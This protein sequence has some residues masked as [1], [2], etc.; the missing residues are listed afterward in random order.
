M[1]KIILLFSCFFS[2]IAFAQQQTVTYSVSPAIF[3]ETTAITITIN[4]NSINESG[5]G[6]TGNALYLWAWAFAADDTTAKGTPDNGAWEA[7]SEA[8]KFTYNAATDTYTKTITPATYYNATA[9]GKIGFLI[10][11]KNGTGDKKS[12]DIFAEV[13][14]FQLTLTA[15]VENST[16]V[17]TSGSNFTIS[18]T[19]TGGNAAYVLKANGTTLNSNSS[20]AS[21]SYTH[22]DLT[23]GFTQIN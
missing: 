8:S 5:W 20:T 7:S 12:Q 14:G 9:L 10:K 17:I 18:T 19:N 15:P 1:K 22:W 16:T 2:I 6:V 3:E 13:G 21:F 23:K 11:A 4:G